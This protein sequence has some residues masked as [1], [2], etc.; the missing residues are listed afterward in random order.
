MDINNFSRNSFVTW[1][2]SLVERIEKA[3]REDLQMRNYSGLTKDGN[4]V[5]GWYA[6]V[7]DRHFILI[8]RCNLDYEEH[9]E[10][11]LVFFRGIIEVIPETVGQ[12]IG[13]KDKN[14]QEIYEGDIICYQVPEKSSNGKLNLNKSIT[15]EKTV[16]WSEFSCGYNLTK[17]DKP[18]YEVIGN[19]HQ[20]K[21]MEQNNA[22]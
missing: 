5:F 12:Q 16:E 20:P 18:I 8:D 11:Y 1:T 15:K 2:T 7:E 14:K 21:L 9:D 3:E 6:K 22:R 13:L 19:I 17:L 4:W 10:G